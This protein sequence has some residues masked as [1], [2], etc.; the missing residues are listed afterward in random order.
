MKQNPTFWGTC[1]LSLL[2]LTGCG[3]EKSENAD[4]KE[5]TEQ[6]AE[7]DA[8]KVSEEPPKEE[9]KSLAD[10]IAG[11]WELVKTFDPSGA[12]TKA[13]G[14]LSFTASDFTD[15]NKY[16]SDAEARTIKGTWRLN[17]EAKNEDGALDCI[18]MKTADEGEVNWNLMSVSKDELVLVFTTMP[19]KRVYKRK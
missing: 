9:K 4:K 19:E 17:P 11:E 1:A 16:S 15:I 18:A 6:K 13:T 7:K 5:K 8:P 2:L 14:S 3:G 10:Q 12:E